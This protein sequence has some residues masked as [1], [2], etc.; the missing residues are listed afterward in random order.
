MSARLATRIDRYVDAVR[1]LSGL[2]RAQQEE[3]EVDRSSAIL[4]ARAELR[5]AEAQLTGGAL[6]M[7]RRILNGG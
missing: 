2:R 4:L 7:A 3:P 1:A 6:A 5:Q